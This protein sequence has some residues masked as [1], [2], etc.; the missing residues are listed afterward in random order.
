MYQ[1]VILEN[2]AFI[3]LALLSTHGVKHPKEEANKKIKSLF[4][5][6]NYKEKIS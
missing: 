1:V 4:Q 6:K 3:V 5:E 2:K